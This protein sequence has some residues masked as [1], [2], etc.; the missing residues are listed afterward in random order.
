MDFDFNSMAM[1]TMKGT[2]KDS[3]YVVVAKADDLKLGIRPLITAEPRE[4]DGKQYIVGMVAMRLRVET[5]GPNGVVSMASSA[6]GIGDFAEKEGG[7]ASRLIR[8]PIGLA[9]LSLTEVKDRM[10]KFDP[11][12]A[13][14]NAIE[15]R[16]SKV[17]TPMAKPIADLKMWCDDLMAKQLPDLPTMDELGIE[18]AV[19]I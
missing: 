15:E 6:F 17:E 12:T 11:I 10:E 13:L 14:L 16:L 8:F 5:C 7:H 18:P 19:E 1:E 9:P 2:E 4:I 3:V